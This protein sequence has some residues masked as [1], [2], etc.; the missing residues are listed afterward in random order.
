MGSLS[1]FVP[2]FGFIP[3][4]GGTSKGEGRYS[5]TASKRSCTVAILLSPPKIGKN[6]PETTPFRIA[7]LNSVSSGSFPSRYFA[8]AWSSNSETASTSSALYF[9]DTSKYSAGISSSLSS[10]SSIPVYVYAFILMMSITPRS[11][12]SSPTGYSIGEALAPNFSRIDF[13]DP[14]KSAPI[15]FNLFNMQTL[16]TLYLSACL[17]TV[18]D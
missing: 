9:F 8:K 17:Q 4:T 15:K 7:R 3:V 18:S 14:S 6:L 16:G 12:C 1:S 11:E 13:I 2:V 5:T 10:L